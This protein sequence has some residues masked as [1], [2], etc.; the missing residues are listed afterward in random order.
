MWKLYLGV[1]LCFTGIAIPLGIAF[2]IYHVIDMRK[3]DTKV[4]AHKSN[5]MKGWTHK[6]FI[7]NKDLRLNNE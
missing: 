1:F 4:S 7:N 5:G 3:D 2:I 6:S